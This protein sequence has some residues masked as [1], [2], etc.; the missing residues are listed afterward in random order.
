MKHLLLFV[1]ML[2]ALPAWARTLTPAEALQ[3]TQGNMHIKS[4]SKRQPRLV[5]T[6]YTAKQLPAYYIFDH[7]DCNGFMVISA[8]DVAMPLLGYSDSGSIDP[9]NM[10]ENMRAWL[11]YYANEIEW[12]AERE[13]SGIRHIRQPLADKIMNARN[14][15]EPIAPLCSTKWNQGSPYNLY[16]PALS[17]G[18][19]ATGCVATA[20]AQLMK[21]HNHPTTGTG[22]A[23]YQWRNPET[24]VTHTLSM[25]FSTVIF[26]WD[27]MLDTYTSDNYSSENANAVAK[28][29]QACGYSVAMNYGPSSG[30]N[31]YNV[32]TALKQNFGYSNATRPY[33]REFYGLDI[34]EEKLYNNLKEVGPIYYSGANDE[35]GHAFIIDGYSGNGYFHLNWGWGGMSDGDFLITALDPS[36][37]GIGG[38]MD[39]YNIG[40][41]AILGAK[42]GNE[43]TEPVPFELGIQSNMTATVSYRTLYLSSVF[44]NIGDYA[45]GPIVGLQFCD[46]AGEQ[47]EYTAIDGMYGEWGHASYISEIAATIP[48]GL[49]QGT[50]KVYPV[51]SIDNGA[52]YNQATPGVGVMPYVLLTK[53]SDG[54]YEATTETFSNATFDKFTLDTHVYAERNFKVSAEIRNPNDSEIMQ[55][56]S[57]GFADASGNIA[58][59]CPSVVVNLRGGE[60]LTLP[61]SNSISAGKITAGETYYMVYYDNNTYAILSDPISVTVQENP[62]DA[63]L[64]L[65]NGGFSIVNPNN[66]NAK[67][68]HINYNV[69]CQEGFYDSPLYMY[70]FDAE[71]HAYVDGLITPPLF[72]NAGGNATATDFSIGGSTNLTAGKRYIAFLYYL[73]GAYNLDYLNNGYTFTVGSFN[74]IDIIE[75]DGNDSSVK[76]TMKDGI[77]SIT[78][79]SEIKSI[80]IYNMSG[81]KVASSEF[82]P[83]NLTEVQKGVYIVKVITYQG[84]ASFKII[85]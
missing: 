6:G 26:M 41:V 62:G 48:S 78:A 76:A 72:I 33:E 56:I 17:N 53:N 16:A 38:S 67:D 60:T 4:D 64:R 77:L 42:P 80:D 70:I 50:Y 21:Y 54:S 27:K 81:A 9:D 23:S 69:Y 24:K 36:N 11:E 83:M 47:P 18:N 14:T 39:G 82:S 28:L 46:Y 34:W 65:A 29:M 15:R 31:S 3:R 1:S 30:A 8:D 44:V 32:A 40:Q 22:S 45:S 55:E 19:C 66:V 43:A 58:A 63:V 35:A 20:M 2:L 13:S 79:D 59:K 10:P 5:K 57:L 71:S 74:S 12:A 68:I 49:Q 73:S 7:T 85:R 84:T 37:Q 75:A 52:T 51:Y 25:D 61:I